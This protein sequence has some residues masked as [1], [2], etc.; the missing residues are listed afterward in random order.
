METAQAGAIVNIEKHDAA[1]NYQVFISHST[2]NADV[3]S[4]MKSFLES[5]GIRCWKAPEDIP[6]GTVWSTGIMRGLKEC[7]IVVLIFSKEADD[8]TNVLKE[9]A[10]ADN[11]KKIIVPFRIEDCLPG[12]EKLGYFL[13]MPQWLDA[14]NSLEAAFNQL[15]TRLRGL[16]PVVEALND[17]PDANDD[18]V[19][20]VLE[21]DTGDT[22]V[23]PLNDVDDASEDSLIITDPAVIIRISASYTPGMPEEELQQASLGDWS[24][25]LDKASQAKFAYV[26]N[27]GQVIAVYQLTGCNETD[28]VNKLGKRRVR[29]SGS[30]CLEKSDDIGKS[31]R[32]YFP[33]GR[34]AANP[35]KYLNIDSPQPREQNLA[36]KKDST[37]YQFNGMTLGKGRLVLEVIRKHSVD[38]PSLSFGELEDAFPQSLQGSGGVFARSEDADKI[39]A[40]SGRKRHFLNADELIKISDATIA[41]SSQWGAGNIDKFVEKARHNGYEIEAVS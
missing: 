24:I 41:V 35:V 21:E 29:F 22:L 8:S 1:M 31:I 33:A 23:E 30:K 28:S 3:A 6:A 4:A 19:E 12:D 38:N 34:G 36:R 27:K 2:R 18:S 14:F 32:H 20:N 5:Q 40:E 25:S 15:S 39:L 7:P 37:K 26:A 11:F 10:L 16:L 13:C 17:S 9:I